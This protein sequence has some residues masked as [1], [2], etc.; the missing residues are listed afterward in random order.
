MAPAG[1]V[2]ATQVSRRKSFLVDREVQ[3]AIVLRSMVHY[4][5]FIA[6]AFLFAGSLQA[7]VEH[8]CNS[9]S[10]LMRY[11]VSRNALS[12]LVG[13]SLMPVFVYDTIRAT[14]RFAGPI[15]RL[16][17]ALRAIGKGERAQL[18]QLRRDDFWQDLA[19][20]WNKAVEKL[21]QSSSQQSSL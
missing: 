14:N 19:T 8:P 16:R 15:S 1:P 12:L 2:H 13:V 17:G 21:H 9:F 6:V 5:V 4:V 18:M 3:T 7:L 10:E 20:E 11:V